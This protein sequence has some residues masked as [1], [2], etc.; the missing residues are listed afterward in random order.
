MPTQV[1]AGSN[2]AA[3]T[4]WGEHRGRLSRGDVL[5]QLT[6]TGQED[7]RAAPV[8]SSPPATTSGSTVQGEF[9]AQIW[10]AAKRRNSPTSDIV[11]WV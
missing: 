11:E 3:G 10:R 1:C 8:A 5:L 4:L 7:V 2:D 9:G 6:C